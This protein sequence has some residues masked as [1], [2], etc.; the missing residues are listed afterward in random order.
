MATKKEAMLQEQRVAAESSHHPGWPLQAW[1]R[2]P[3]P[4]SCSVFPTPYFPFP[5]HPSLFT[6]PHS[7]FTILDSR[8]SPNIVRLIQLWTNLAL[9]I[10]TFILYHIC[11]IQ[12][13]SCRPL[14]TMRPSDHEHP[15]PPHYPNDATTKLQNSQTKTIRT[16]IFFARFFLWLRANS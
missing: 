14:T 15:Q 8:F 7:P 4:F 10:R 3:L 9:D 11:E 12:L 6:T 2:P 13:S 5:I 1:R 16:S